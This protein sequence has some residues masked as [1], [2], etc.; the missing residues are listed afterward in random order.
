M[1]FNLYS[2]V[3]FLQGIHRALVAVVGERRHEHSALFEDIELLRLSDRSRA[4][5]VRKL[6][7]DMPYQDF[8]DAW[9]KLLLLFEA[10]QGLRGEIYKRL[11]NYLGEATR[12]WLLAKILDDDIFQLAVRN[13][14]VWSQRIEACQELAAHFDELFVRVVSDFRAVEA[15]ARGDRVAPLTVPRDENYLVAVIKHAIDAQNQLPGSWRALDAALTLNPRLASLFER[16]GWIRQ[17]GRRP[18]VRR[19]QRAVRKVV[20]FVEI[21]ERR[22]SWRGFLLAHFRTITKRRVD[23][24]GDIRLEPFEERI[25]GHDDEKGDWLAQHH[26]DEAPQPVR[27]LSYNK[28]FFPVEIDGADLRVEVAAE[29]ASFGVAWL[30]VL[31]RGARTPSFSGLI[32]V[33]ASADPNVRQCVLNLRDLLRRAPRAA[34]EYAGHLCPVTECN[35]RHFR[36][37]QVSALLEKV[38]PN[39][40]ELRG[41][42]TDLIELLERSREPRRVR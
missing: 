38:A 21:F 18:G 9:K 26:H 24:F 22:F 37:E 17:V 34:T 14:A 3:R 33:P 8:P 35:W 5:L 40:E 4:D 36:L 27:D 2:D 16:A 19:L 30:V 41:A 11:P 15:M 31:R 39:D 6:I 1:D 23:Q 25:Y 20:A 13:A 10:D 12:D 29:Q 28:V 42:V 32:A 7:A